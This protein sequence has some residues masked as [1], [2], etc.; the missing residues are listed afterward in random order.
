MKR[1][2]FR[3]LG[4]IFLPPSKGEIQSGSEIMKRLFFRGLSKIFLPLPRGRYREGQKS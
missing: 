2:Y 4:K 3:G 1:L